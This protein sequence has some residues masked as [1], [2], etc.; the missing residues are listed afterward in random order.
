MWDEVTTLY[1]TATN[2]GS[3]SGIAGA[4]TII[5]SLMDV[6]GIYIT[7]RGGSPTQSCLEYRCDASY[8]Y[9][10]SNNLGHY[11]YST[12][13]PRPS[14]ETRYLYRLP[15]QKTAVTTQ[16]TAQNADTLTN[17]SAAYDQ[18]LAF[19]D[20]STTG[21]PSG[22]C[23]A[24]PMQTT[25]YLYDDVAG[26]RTYYRKVN[27]LIT[28][29][30]VNSG[31]QLISSTE[32]GNG[33]FG[34]PAYYFPDTAAQSYEGT[35]DGVPS[36]DLCGGHGHH[37]AANERCFKLAADRKPLYSYSQATSTFNFQSWID[38]ACSEVSGIVGY[39]F[40]GTPIKGPC[41]CMARDGLGNCTSIKRVRSSFV[42]S[43]LGAWGNDADEAAAL[44]Q[45]GAACSSDSD[46][47]DSHFQCSWSVFDDDNAVGGTTVRKG[48]VLVDYAWCTH[49][50]VNRSAENVSA[51]NFV[52]L[53]RCNGVTDADGYAYH[54][55]GS[56]PFVPSCLR[57]EPSES[58]TDANLD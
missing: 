43:G 31:V 36:L 18:Y 32:A 45:E 6:S 47:N 39:M 17:C 52:Y 10:A 44:G 3:C 20:T 5:D 16:A 26:N 30:F 4:Q 7:P 21:E 38:S 56:F 33:S 51:A 50:Y 2:L 1:P 41:V 53:D 12:N 54:A 8:I 24:S 35:A 13:N 48:C 9:I 14:S 23:L 49:A 34:G 58:A 37:H 55:T 42:Y 19:P 15:L 28:N 29:G 40:D 22:Y 46:C 25:K 27:C 57:Y 11:Q